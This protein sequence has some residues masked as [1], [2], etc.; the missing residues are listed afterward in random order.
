[1]KE[2]VFNARDRREFAL[3]S[4]RKGVLR[5][6]SPGVLTA[7]LLWARRSRSTNQVALDTEGVL[8]GKN[9]LIVEG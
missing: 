5:K 6:I 3:F 9:I 7:R 8:S 1:M 2:P 4:N